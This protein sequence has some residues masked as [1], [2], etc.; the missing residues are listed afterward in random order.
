MTVLPH[1]TD[2]L[3]RISDAVDGFLRAEREL[4]LADPSAH[5]QVG[6]RVHA[7]GVQIHGGVLAGIPEEDIAAIVQPARSAC[8]R[9]PFMRDENEWARGY[10][11]DF[12]LIEHVLAQANKATPGTLGWHVETHLQGVA[13]THQ[14]RNRVMHQTRLIGDTLTAPRNEPR[15]VLVIAAGSAPDL[16]KIPP[17]IVRP[18][19]RFVLTD[20]DPDALELAQQRLGPLNDFT[21][22]VS[23]N[24]FRAIPKLAELG[25]YDL[26]LVNGLYEYLNDRAAARLTEAVLTRLCRPGGL[27]HFSSLTG[28]NPFRWALEYLMEWQVV[29]RDEAAVRA[30]LPGCDVSVGFDQTGLALLAHVRTRR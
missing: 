18:G 20:V 14:L 25:P 10:P 27:F 30:L 7:L 1:T 28:G 23:G 5:M 17:G 26:V 11:S 15:S 3:H 2:A 24:V 4:N 6:G 19:D 9:S 22:A 8:A 29:E 12:R 21:T 16:R 13:I